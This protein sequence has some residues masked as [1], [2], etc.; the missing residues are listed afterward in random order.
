MSGELR[1]SQFRWTTTADDDFVI[2][3]PDPTVVLTHPTKALV[4]Q[5]SSLPGYINN[6]SL[7]CQWDGISAWKFKFS[8][9]GGTTDSQISGVAYLA[10]TGPQVFT[11]NNTFS[12]ATTIISG[13]TINLGTN[14]TDTVNV[15][16]VLNVTGAINHVNTTNLDVTDMTI[17]LNKGGAL[18]SARVSGIELEEGSGL[19]G[20]IRTNAAGTGWDF[21]APEVAGTTTFLPSAN[22]ISLTLPSVTGT[23]ARIEDISMTANRVVLS[24][25]TGNGLTP[26]SV[27]NTELG[28]VSGVTGAIQTQFT[29]VVHLAGTETITG[30]KTFNQKLILVD[31][32]TST[33]YYVYMNSGTLTVAP[34]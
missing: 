11:G 20:Y 14:I 1:T 26:S 30:S 12:G 6:P 15:K 21:K 9:D 7:L 23:L 10:G 13:S 22:T 25:G 27:T 16:G 3:N 33:L 28:Y 24:N 4:F 5:S 2:G 17:T 34:V 32:T 29:N 8:T 31:Q 18:H 19:A